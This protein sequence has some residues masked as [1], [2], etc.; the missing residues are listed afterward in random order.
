MLFD[1]V[2][3]FSDDLRN[4]RTRMKSLFIRS[5]SS[6]DNPNELSSSCAEDILCAPQSK[7]PAVF[8]LLQSHATNDISSG[9]QPSQS[10]LQCLSDSGCFRSC[11][12]AKV[13]QQLG[14]PVC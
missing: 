8:L 10:M 12:D 13:V 1:D 2:D 9:I 7:S 14:I 4:I 6:S 5:L 11:I 3:Q